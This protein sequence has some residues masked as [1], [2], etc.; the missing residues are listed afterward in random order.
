MEARPSEKIKKIEPDDSGTASQA[1]RAVASVGMGAAGVGLNMVS[2]GFYGALK[3]AWDNERQREFFREL[4]KYID[5]KNAEFS[6]KLTKQEAEIEEL[7][8]DTKHMRDERL[9]RI[10]EEAAAAAAK[11]EAEA[12]EAEVSRVRAQNL[13][14][15]PSAREEADRPQDLGDAQSMR[16][17]ERR[18][19]HEESAAKKRE[20]A[21]KKR[22][23]AAKKREEA[24]LSLVEQELANVRQ[25]Q[26]EQKGLSRHASLP[27]NARPNVRLATVLSQL[28]PED[29]QDTARGGGKSKRKKKN[30]TK[31]R[32]KTKR[33][34]TQR[35]KKTKRC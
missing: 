15:N 26:R 18:Q 11:A 19:K 6:K 7:K 13:S 34:K 22:E 14:W 25:Q 28:G 23:E 20:E 10:T 21:A 5:F 17:A 8:E 32:K 27:A 1:A 3:N 2:L 16:L 12:K 31:R 29:D 33:K 24:R 4:L 35:N 9:E 30:K